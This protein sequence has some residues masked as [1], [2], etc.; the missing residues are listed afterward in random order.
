MCLPAGLKE[1]LCFARKNG[2]EWL[3]R[4]YKEPW[5]YKR[6]LIAAFRHTGIKNRMKKNFGS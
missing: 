3:Y 5:K 2:L 4:L 6:R 1:L